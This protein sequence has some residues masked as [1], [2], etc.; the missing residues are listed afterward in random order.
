MNLH[1]NLLMNPLGVPELTCVRQELEPLSSKPSSLCLEVG[2]HRLARRHVSQFTCVDQRLIPKHHSF[3]EVGLHR[4]AGRKRKRDVATKWSGHFSDK[5]S[6]SKPIKESQTG[7]T[8]DLWWSP[9]ETQQFQLQARM[10]LRMPMKQRLRFPEHFE[11][12]ETMFQ[13]CIRHSRE[14]RVV[15]EHWNPV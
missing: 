10:E 14:H 6:E 8:K 5:V 13:D 1:I 4:F 7:D 2:L 11:N 15:P 3:Q 9:S 12:F